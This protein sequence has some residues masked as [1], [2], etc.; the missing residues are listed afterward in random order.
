MSSSTTS[1]VSE[2]SQFNSHRNVEN[3]LP[4]NT[5]SWSIDLI[6]KFGIRKVPSS[7]FELIRTNGR[8]EIL[9]TM[10]YLE[11]MKL[12]KYVVYHVWISIH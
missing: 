5:N 1:D 2:L 7:L 11:L 8:Y 3:D 4:S 12:L 10:K 9:P 6:D